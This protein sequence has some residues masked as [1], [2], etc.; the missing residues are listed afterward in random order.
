MEVHKPKPWHGWRELAKEIGTI[1]QKNMIGKI[2]FDLV[3]GGRTVGSINAE[4]WRAWNFNIQN[5]N[6]KEVA[7]IKV[8]RSP[9]RNITMVQR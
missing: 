9:K 1:V 6:G 8:G 3:A 5:H 2:H 7:R 4:N